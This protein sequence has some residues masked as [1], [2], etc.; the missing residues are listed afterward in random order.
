MYYIQLNNLCKKITILIGLLWSFQ[1]LNAQEERDVILKSGYNA[2]QFDANISLTYLNEKIS[3][4]N[5][6]S[7]QGEGQ[8]SVYKKEYIDNGTSFLNS[9]SQTSF[10]KAYW[11]NVDKDVTFS[12]LPKVYTGTKS[13]ELSAG[14]NFIGPLDTLTLSEIQKQLSME[15]LLAI[16]GV[17]Q[18]RT[19]KKEYIKDGTPYLNSFKAFEI[20]QGYWIKVNEFST[21]SFVFES[22]VVVLKREAK[23]KIEAYAQNSTNPTPTLQDYIDAGVV[24]V[25]RENLE[26]VNRTVENATKEEL[27][28][29]AELNRL[30]SN[31]CITLENLKVKIANNEDV[32]QIN[33]GCITD[34]SDLFKNNRMFNQ[35]I[36]T[37]NVS[38]VTNM[39]SMFNGAENF[40][41]DISSWNVSNV[42]NMYAM[43]VGVRNINQSNI[44]DWDMFNVINAEHMFDSKITFNKYLGTWNLYYS[45]HSAAYKTNVNA[46]PNSLGAL[47]YCIE[48]GIIFDGDIQLSRDNVLIMSHDNPGY[49]KD[50]TTLDEI[51]SYIKNDAPNTFIQLEAKYFD[52]NPSDIRERDI[53]PI[54]N[55]IKDYD[56]F[57]NVMI[58]SRS[59][60]GAIFIKKY[61]DTINVNNA[62]IG[63]WVYNQYTYAGDSHKRVRDLIMKV[64][65]NNYKYVDL[66]GLYGSH[67]FP[68]GI[69]ELNKNIEIQMLFSDSTPPLG[70]LN[71]YKE[72]GLT[73]VASDYPEEYLDSGLF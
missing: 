7:V 4:E 49:A 24:G 5:L 32:T 51:L 54:L 46:A 2:V 69:R 57:N 52:W 73:H 29:I 30:V 48:K 50:Y 62:H 59:I 37:W 27:D 22:A 16:Q 14:W 65:K 13:I 26:A 1:L 6:I 63:I 31:P 12:Y 41:H 38:H 9:F 53:V 25:T 60:E 72:K 40:N 20:G 39:E 43:F 18:E 58:W 47:K 17:G 11:I 56:V 66:V 67:G 36:G 8:D 45:L 68:D 42:T 23:N 71:N 70:T 19:Y 33:T 35:N 44:E 15:N 34:M 10:G 21:L 61:L 55:K 64:A 28:T 3:F